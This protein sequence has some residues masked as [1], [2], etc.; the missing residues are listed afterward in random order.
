MEIEESEAGF[1]LGCM[2]GAEA[3]QRQHL[4]RGLG[5]ISS[6]NDDGVQ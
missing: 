1:L 6:L 2:D 5:S 3:L 4:R